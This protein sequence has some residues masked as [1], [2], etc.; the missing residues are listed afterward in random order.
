MGER[1][2]LFTPELSCGCLPGTSRAA[3]IAALKAEGEAVIEGRF[4]PEVL[5]QA[6]A[7]FV[8]NAV[9]G[10]VPLSRVD[11][12]GYSTED[13]QLSRMKALCDAAL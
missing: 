9:R 2:R 13:S 4:A 11:D 3:L 8:T 6:D 1:G 5:M 10:A 12:R 7:V